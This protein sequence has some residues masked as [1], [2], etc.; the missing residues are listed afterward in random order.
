MPLIVNSVPSAT[1][2]SVAINWFDSFLLAVVVKFI[3]VLSL[4]TSKY[5]EFVFEILRFSWVWTLNPNVEISLTKS[6][7]SKDVA[8]CD[9]FDAAILASAKVPDVILLADKFG[10]LSVLQIYL[11][12][13]R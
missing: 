4:N 7:S 8:C 5:A 1:V 10:Y 11:N 9:T 13:E 12:M 3:P 2:P 6:L